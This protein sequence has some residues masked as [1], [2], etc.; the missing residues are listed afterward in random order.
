MSFTTNAIQFVASDVLAA[1]SAS[2]DVRDIAKEERALFGMC[3]LVR[4]LCWMI[5]LVGLIRGGCST[6]TI[7][8]GGNSS[9]FNLYGVLCVQN[10]SHQMPLWQELYD[11]SRQEGFMRARTPF[12]TWSVKMYCA[13]LKM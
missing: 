3:L 10:L 5:I 11:L 13:D 6:E 4:K 1:T 2:K 12:I 7:S 9:R 8:I